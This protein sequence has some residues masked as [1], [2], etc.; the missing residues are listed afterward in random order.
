M[1]L[2]ESQRGLPLEV[3]VV[4]SNLEPPLGN[5]LSPKDN[6]IDY[7]KERNDDV[8]VMYERE[9]GRWNNLPSKITDHDKIKNHTL[10]CYR[11]DVKQEDSNGLTAIKI[12]EKEPEHTLP[13]QLKTQDHSKKIIPAI[14]QKQVLDNVAVDLEYKTR[15]ESENANKCIGVD[16][17]R[18]HEIEN[19]TSSE[20][21][22]I[23]ESDAVSIHDENE[24]VNTFLNELYDKKLDLNNKFSSQDIKDIRGAVQDIVKQLAETIGK[25]DPRLKI[26]EVISVGSAK[27]STQIIRPCEFDYIL[28]LGALSKA[29]IVS[30][31]SGIKKQFVYVKLEDDDVKHMFQECSENNYLRGSRSLPC[32]RQGLREVFC[33]ALYEA[34]RLNSR[35]SIKKSTGKLTARRSKPESHGPAFMFGLIWERETTKKYTT[36]EISIDLC[37]ALKLDY[38]PA[39]KFDIVPYYYE[40]LDIIESIDSVLLMP[41]IEHL[42]KVTFTETQLLYTSHLSP[43]HRKCYKL[44]KYLVNGEPFPRETPTAKIIT[45]FMG[46]KT[47]FHSYKLKTE[48]WDHQFKQKCTEDKDLSSCIYRVIQGI[49]DASS[50]TD[51]FKRLPN[52][53]GQSLLRLRTLQEGL[54]KIKNTRIETY[55]FEESCRFIAYR[56]FQSCPAQISAILLCARF[57]IML[58]IFGI[59]LLFILIQLETANKV[60]LVIGALWFVCGIRC[61][62]LSKHGAKYLERRLLAIHSP[63]LSVLG[64]F[65]CLQCLLYLLWVSLSLLPGYVIFCM[66]HTGWLRIASVFLC[67]VIF[68]FD[69][70]ILKCC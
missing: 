13:R 70:I 56:G 23:L 39:L 49:E 42:F 46:S 21:D 24:T 48:V 35:I 29:D 27:E 63:T 68:I 14:G 3:N 10:V 25:I 18:I 22:Q 59:A 57:K 12:R 2:T 33:S 16:I 52:K 5:N 66:F 6:V 4:I 62:D 50:T 15:K 8:T 20:A 38:S 31:E 61:Y 37:P 51:I 30:L 60:T 7:Q 55:N 11:N 17:G 54:K 69:M 34:I 36:M 26:Q 41:H 19:N 64:I 67:I 43:H 53:R 32:F 44:L 58:V 1:S 40:R 45:P 9:N 47:V 65:R 28:P